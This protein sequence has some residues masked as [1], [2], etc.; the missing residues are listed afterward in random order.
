M[1]TTS[2]VAKGVV[3]LVAAVAVPAFIAAAVGLLW[4]GD[5]ASF[6]FTTLRGDSVQ[7]YGEGLYRFD[8]VMGGSGYR[9]V[10]LATLLVGLPLLVGSTILWRWGSLRGTLLLIGALSYFLYNYASLALGASYNRLFLVYVLTFAASLFALVL[11]LTAFDRAAFAASLSPHMPTRGIGAVL[12]ATFGVL[13]AVWLLPA[14]LA[15][16]ADEAPSVLASYTTVI[17]W[18]LD[19]AIILPL[20]LVAAIL[21]LRDKPLGYLIAAPI[22]IVTLMLGPALTAMTVAQLLAGVA[23]TPAEL[24]G[25]VA[26]FLVLSLFGMAGAV[27]LLRNVGRDTGRSRAADPPAAHT[28]SSHA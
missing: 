20:A 12:L 15:A 23:F 26:G 16:V 3:C 17:T 14:I 27:A 9:G 19:I 2:V 4:Q 18:A 8:T 11:V 5:G 22:L 10:D 21:V 1:N 25:P 28:A 7:V 13:T 24:I 6:T